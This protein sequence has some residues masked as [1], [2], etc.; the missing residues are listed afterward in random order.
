VAAVLVIML[1]LVAAAPTST[2][3][4]VMRGEACEL[5]RRNSPAPGSVFATET[6]GSNHSMSPVF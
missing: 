3:E 1:T 6:T 2:L 4:Q 5:F